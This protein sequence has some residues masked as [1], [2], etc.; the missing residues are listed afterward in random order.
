MFVM[1]HS[2]CRSQVSLVPVQAVLKPAELFLIDSQLLLQSFV[3]T[4]ELIN[5]GV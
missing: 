3:L 2:L 4:V 1:M 5:L